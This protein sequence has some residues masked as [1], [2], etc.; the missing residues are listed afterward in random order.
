MAS[1]WTQRETLYGGA[2]DLVY[3]LDTAGNLTALAEFDGSPSELVRDTSGNLYFTSGDPG[4][5]YKLETNGDLKSLYS[6]TGIAV[7]GLSG[8]NATP[9]VDAA[10]NLYGTSSNDGSA[11]IVYG[12]EAGGTFKMLYNFQPAIGG[13]GPYFGVTL[14]GAGN[15]FGTTNGGGIPLNLGVVYKLSPVGQETVL[16]T[17]QGGSADGANPVGN[18][19]LD[20]AG[21]LYGVTTNA[22]A[23]NHGVVYKLS[24]TGGQTILHS[25]AGGSDGIYP[26]GLARD[27]AGNLYGAAGGGGADND[28]VVYKL[29][30][31]GVETILHTFTNGADGYDPDSL[32]L[33]SVGNVYGTTYYGGVLGS[34]VLYKIDSTGA[35]S[36]LHN[37]VSATDGSYCNSVT[38]DAVGDLYGTCS[39]GGAQDWGTVFKLSAAGNFSTLYSFK[40]ISED[41]GQPS[42]TLMLD[43]A[44][45]LYGTTSSGGL[46][47]LHPTA[48]G[49]VFKIDT[50]G[51]YRVLHAFS[52]ATDGEGPGAGVALDSA[53]SLYGTCSFWGPGGGGTLFKIAS[54]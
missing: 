53:G 9:V 17:F 2:Q 47:S 25:F 44:G 37:F 36:V 8:P 5:V 51:A 30:P 19:V 27:T 28:G 4:S 14:D 38:A 32:A 16:H 13:T 21:S 18:V 39:G 50:T 10:G 48:A 34:G 54:E 42:G 15:L 29:T 11:G 40:D 7:T 49:V 43:A 33:D 46:G 45:N 24:P 12:I 31:S 23:D 20:Q 22:G 1:F 35:F 52:P 6:F 41:G 3:K 26:F